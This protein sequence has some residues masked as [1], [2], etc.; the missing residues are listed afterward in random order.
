[1]MNFKIL[2][3]FL[4]VSLT[5]LSQLTVVEK[6]YMDREELIFKKYVGCDSIKTLRVVTD[7]SISEHVTEVLSSKFNIEPGK[8]GVELFCKEII[9]DSNLNVLL[10]KINSGT[11]DYHVKAILNAIYFNKPIM[12]FIK[13]SKIST[14]TI[15][16]F[17]IL[18]K[19]EQSE[20]VVV[21]LGDNE[22][23]FKLYNKREEDE[24]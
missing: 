10:F 5:G 1:M 11:Y 23:V 13:K 21:R 15:N 19:G 20:V 14:I 12:E 24:N 2:L 9:K 17:Q 8:D 22:K 7:D 16:Y 6:Q 3:V 4:L 18:S